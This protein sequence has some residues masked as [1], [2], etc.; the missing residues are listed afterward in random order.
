MDNNSEEIAVNGNE[1]SAV[2]GPDLPARTPEYLCELLGWSKPTFFRH[3]P[4]LPH[5]KIGRRIRFSERQV[6]EIMRSFE[7]KPAE[8]KIDAAVRVVLA[9]L[10]DDGGEA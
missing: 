8:A 4:N 2:L 6:Q 1:S 10:A 3:I 5:Y 9:M 7:R